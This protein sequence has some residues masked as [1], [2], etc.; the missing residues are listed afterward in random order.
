MHERQ[1]RDHIPLSADTLAA[2]RFAVSPRMQA[3][4]LLHPSR[5]RAMGDDSL[6]YGEG[7]QRA[8]GTSNASAG[9]STPVDADTVIHWYGEHETSWLLRRVLPRYLQ[10]FMQGIAEGLARYAEERKPTQ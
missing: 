1:I 3:G 9:R 2:I 10:K 4:A 5:P 7:Q 8:V 6:S